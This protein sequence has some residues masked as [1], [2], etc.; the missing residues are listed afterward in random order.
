VS[1][2]SPAAVI[3]R[4]YRAGLARVEGR[5]AVRD[6]VHL[7]GRRLTIGAAGFDLD[8]L[9]RI[10]VIGAGKA[11]AA[12]AQGL[13]DALG[14]RI[15][16]G[17]ITTKDDH[18]L[19]TRRIVIREAAHPTP[20][21]RCLTAAAVMLDLLRDLS[22]RDLVIAL[23]SGGGS[24]LVE[25][26]VPGIGLEDLIALTRLLLR[27]GATIHEINTIRKHLSTIKGGGLARL[28]QPARL[29]NLMISDVIGDDLDTIASGPT[30]PDTT[31]YAD[32]LAVLDRYRLRESAPPAVRAY[33]EAGA[34]GDR[35]ETAKP[36][37][38]AFA[39]VSNVL[40][41]TNALAIEAAAA[42]AERLGYRPLVLSTMIQG[43]AREIARLWAAI[44]LQAVHDGRPAAAPCCLLGGGEATVT[45]A[46]NGRGGRNTEFALAAAL[47]IAGSRRL[48]IASLATDGSDGPT[49][50]V[51]AIVDGDTI[52][53]AHA[54]GL[55]PSAFLRANDSYTFFDRLGGLVRTGPTG[56]NVNDLYLTLV[57][58]A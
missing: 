27:S 14:D 13:E 29:V 19:P 21:A 41:A 9:D 3:E 18:S 12:M 43:E 52:A 23:M 17:A 2:A 15:T 32:A 7:D 4:I 48:T 37:D 57:E 55:D 30:V 51:G 44:G 47:A 1:S 24:A 8:T 11:S 36:G 54:A 58:P 25:A 56:T 6:A 42:E 45:L 50:A 38:P 33:L 5:A 46:G 49:D 34:T 39:R 35:P 40:V 16:A 10:L 31:T 53:A 22:E 28:V 26:L 20:D